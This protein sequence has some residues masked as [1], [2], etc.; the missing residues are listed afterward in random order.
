MGLALKELGQGRLFAIDPHTRTDWNDTESVDT[1]EIMRSNLK[2]F[3]VEDQVEILRCFSARAAEQW[4]RPIDLLFID[5]DHSCEGV[6]RDW[7]LFAPH[8]KEFG[9]V[10]FHDTI[11]ERYPD[12][13]RWARGDMGVPRFLDEL[14]NEG[15]PV[16]TIAEHFGISLVQPTRGGV[17][18]EAGTAK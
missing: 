2:R 18:L 15:F 12:P 3:G 9:I 7:A 16:I 17:P 11:W 1:L 13:P 5:G 10:M 14:R 8:V 4:S 6:K